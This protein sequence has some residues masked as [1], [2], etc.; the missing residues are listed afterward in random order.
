MARDLRRDARIV[1]RPHGD[2][3]L[4][5]IAEH[6]L[7]RLGGHPFGESL[8]D[9]SVYQDA[10]RRRADLP[11]IDEAARGRRCGGSIEIGIFEDYHRTVAAEFHQLWFAGRTEA[12][13]LAGR[14]TSGETDR[15]RSRI[16]NDLVADHGA[17]AGDEV[18]HAW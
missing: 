17:R 3:I 8:I 2:P 9:R 12:D 15:I 13:L 1:E 6:D 10:L 11:G 14:R 18:Q 16:G 7:A 5:R 4:A